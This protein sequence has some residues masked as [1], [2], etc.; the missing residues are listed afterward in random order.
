MKILD[1]LKQTFFGVALL[2]YLTGCN[3]NITEFGF[4]GS[5][6]GKVIDQSGNIVAG[7][8][9]SN[10]LLVKALGEGDAVTMDIR[11]E[12][13]GSFQNTKLYPKPFKIWITGPVTMMEDTLRVD[14]SKNKIV[15]HD[16]V[17][18]PFITVKPP[19]V[20]GSPSA[21]SITI[22]Y[23]MI[24]NNGNIPDLREVY[25]STVPYPNSSTG[26]G[27]QYMTKK[28]SI[29]NDMGSIEITGLTSKT[30]YFIRIGAR[31]KGSK[32]LNYSDQL[33]VTTP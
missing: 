20:S 25:C 5:I 33:V 3:E 8:I 10:N 27:P 28:L 26:S 15:E 22:N 16:I 6:S 12:G 4:D 1:I 11:V 29:S 17:V 30:K 7:D 2:F 18:T 23:E 21:N 19:V 32:L 24:P 31:S 9:T 14:F 13:D